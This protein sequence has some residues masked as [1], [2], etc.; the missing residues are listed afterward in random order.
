[1]TRAK[2]KRL[3]NHVYSKLLIL[4]ATASENSKDMK[5][6]AWSTFEG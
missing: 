3:E 2:S 1:M 5:I 4:Q 6:M